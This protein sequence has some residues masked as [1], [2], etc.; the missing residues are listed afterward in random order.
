MND[1]APV[2]IP[3]VAHDTLGRHT[4][5]AWLNANAGVPLRYVIGQPGAGKTTAV[6]AW[7]QQ[8]RA[9]IVWVTL[10]D[11]CSRR[12][13][14]ATLTDALANFDERSCTV[15]IDDADRASPEARDFLSQ[16]YLHAP[17]RVTFIYLARGFAAVD[18][19][20]GE[21]RGVVAVTAATQLRFVTED[22][23]LYCEALEVPCTPLDTAW[24]AAATNGWAFAVSGIVRAAQ[25]ARRPLGDAF[26]LWQTANIA[27]IDRLVD[28][29]AKTAPARDAQELLDILDG[30]SAPSTSTLRRLERVGLFV[31]RVEGRFEPNPVVVRRSDESQGTPAVATPLVLELFGRFRLLHD[32]ADVRFVRRRDAQIVQYLALQQHGYATRE[33][34]VRTFWPDTDPQLGAQGLRTACSAIRR[35]IAARVGSDAVERYLFSAPAQIGLRFESVV[36]SAHRFV[37]HAELAAAAEARGSQAFALAH[38]SAA[39]K[40][41]SA[42]VLSGEPVAWWIER[43]AEIFAALALRARRFLREA[44]PARVR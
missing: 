21:Q 1:T 12:W 10:H 32:G 8:R 26:A 29:A 34:L 35:A 38:W 31:E 44:G 25:V 37:L 28:E 43:Q 2:A 33:K 13:L 24:L 40:L 20:H 14:V 27:T 16:L 39:L 17:E 30:E 23:A 22:I 5:W 4:L 3:D 36:S 19:A 18:V 15:I 11:G 9:D 41:Y 7:A 42:P 6:A